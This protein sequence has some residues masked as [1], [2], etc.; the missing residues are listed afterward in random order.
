MM[1]MISDENALSK[2]QNINKHTN[3]CNVRSDGGRDVQH[4]FFQ[5]ED[6]PPVA[7]SI[8]FISRLDPPPI[9]V[10]GNQK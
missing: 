9:T 4:T 5:L 8:Y 2:S 7:F 1:D 6:Y 3:W 10:G